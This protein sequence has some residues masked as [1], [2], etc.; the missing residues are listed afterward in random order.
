MD[1]PTRPSYHRRNRRRRRIT[2]VARR[3]ARFVVTPVVVVLLAALALT[4]VSDGFGTGALL[5]FSPEER[6]AEVPV[7]LPSSAP[8]AGVTSDARTV[9]R[10]ED[11]QPLPNACAPSIR[12]CAPAAERVRW[13]A[14]LGR[15]DAE[16]ARAWRLG[17]PHLL[18]AVYTPRCDAFVLDRRMLA[19]YV[20]R[21]LRVRGVRLQFA[22]VH[23]LTR[24]AGV[25]K[26]RLVDRL[27]AVTAVTPRGEPRSLPRDEATRHQVILHRLGHD[28]RIADV[29]AV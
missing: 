9:R 13:R 8:R 27:A 23:V 6:G 20:A 7:S 15:L 24:R 21:G 10:A 18:R 1:G 19:G 16:R 3:V 29:R 26:L 4:A 17:K 5:D 14:I 12:R 25:V 11:I 2:A 22:R 28:W